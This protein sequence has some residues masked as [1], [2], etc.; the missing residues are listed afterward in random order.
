MT[1]LAA[2]I[3]IMGIGALAWFIGYQSAMKEVARIK[4]HNLE[5]ERLF[6]NFAVEHNIPAHVA[7]AKLGHFNRTHQ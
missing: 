1:L 2:F 3:G 7:R 6:M 4:R 5:I